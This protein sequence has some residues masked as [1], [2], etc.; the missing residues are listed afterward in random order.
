V[1]RILTRNEKK[2]RQN[3]RKNEEQE[4]QARKKERM[5]ILITMP[6]KEK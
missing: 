6:P 3:E 1:H 4:E 5:P 2:E